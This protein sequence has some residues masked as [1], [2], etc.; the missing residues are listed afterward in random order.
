MLLLAAATASP[1]AP[2]TALLAPGNNWFQAAKLPPRP[3]INV[4]MPKSGSSSLADFMACGG[5]KTSH[6]T[7]GKHHLSDKMCNTCLEF[8]HNASKPLL[9][10]CG[11][12]DA[13]AQ[14]D[15]PASAHHSCNGLNYPQITLLDEL[16][17][18]YPSATFVLPT[19]PPAHW[20]ESLDNWNTS[21]ADMEKRE[22]YRPLLANCDLAE[23][24][25]P[26]GVGTT[27][28]ELTDFYNKH[29]E[30]V[31]RFVRAHPS[32]QL[33][34]VD[35]EHSDAGKKLSAAV[36]LPERCWGKSNCHSSCDFWDELD[37]MRADEVA[38]VDVDV[39]EEEVQ[40]EG[41]GAGGGRPE[42]VPSSAG[43]G[44]P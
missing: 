30:A 32:H 40:G 29:T 33:I 26:K 11:D 24:G 31:H 14:I 23:A 10:N 25:F 43:R 9:D 35:I 15:A 20:I 38:K 19:R 3:I 16:H 7:C 18:A 21:V 12:F 41:R 6:F 39:D 17:A 2:H 13:W 42:R 44:P 4:G 5:V 27:D 8:N 37:G 1:A 34:T 28:A 22:T 36:G